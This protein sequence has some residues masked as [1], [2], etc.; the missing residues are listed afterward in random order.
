MDLNDIVVFTKPPNLQVSEDDLIKRVVALPGETVEGHG[1]KVY[2]NG[3]ALD[4]SYVEPLC[5]GTGD[6]GEITVPA[7]KLWV[8][9]DNRCN[10]SDS[11]VFGPI[12]QDLVVGRAFLLAWPFDRLSWL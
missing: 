8:M 12:G 7:G 3:A 2:V 5:H 10:S 6:F 9:G 1:G 4:E 11:R